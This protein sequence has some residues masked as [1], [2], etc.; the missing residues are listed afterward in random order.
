MTRVKACSR[1][2][3]VEEEVKKALILKTPLMVWGLILF[4]VGTY[5]ASY[6][7]RGCKLHGRDDDVS[8][9]VGLECRG[10]GL[11]MLFGGCLPRMVELGWVEDRPP[12]KVTGPLHCGAIG[13]AGRQGLKV[14]YLTR[15]RGSAPTGSVSF[16]GKHRRSSQ[17]ILPLTLPTFSPTTPQ[18]HIHQRISPTRLDNRSDKGGVDLLFCIACFQ[19][20][21]AEKGSGARTRQGWKRG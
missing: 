11:E 13:Q 20:T 6:G 7:Q 4:P 15:S 21:P 3:E 10:L 2:V 14:P 1:M 5:N 9:G 16:G 18:G 19:I 8:L 12:T 17:N